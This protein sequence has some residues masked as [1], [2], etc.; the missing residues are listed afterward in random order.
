MFLLHQLNLTLNNTDLILSLKSLNTCHVMM[1]FLSLFVLQSLI[2]LFL[3]ENVGNIDMKMNFQTQLL[4]GRY[5]A[6]NYTT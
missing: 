5:R 2:F 6:D 4:Q 3:A 1:D